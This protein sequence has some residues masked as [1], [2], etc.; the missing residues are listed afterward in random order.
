MTDNTT[1]ETTSAPTTDA[2]QT[3]TPQVEETNQEPQEGTERGNREAAK[4]RRQLREAEAERDT[5]TSRVEALQK[6]TIEGIA[7]SILKRPAAL[8]ATGTTLA[9][10]LDTSGNIDPAKVTEAAEK[11][12]QELGASPRHLAP[13]IPGQGRTPDAPITAGDTFEAAFAPRH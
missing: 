10:L 7:A 12:Q 9:D 11:A 8:W 1:Q 5:L 13:I 3:D 2:E 6:D 4:Y